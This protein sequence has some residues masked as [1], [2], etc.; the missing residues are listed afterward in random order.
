MSVDCGVFI[1]DFNLNYLKVIGNG[2]VF[3][4]PFYLV[5]VKFQFSRVKNFD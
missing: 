1:Y 4:Q 3:T 5:L 2:F